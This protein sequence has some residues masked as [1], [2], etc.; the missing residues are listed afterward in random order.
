MILCIAILATI[1]LSLAK[2]VSF[3]K[4]KIQPKFNPQIRPQISPIIDLQ[5]INIIIPY[6]N[7]VLETYQPKQNHNQNFN[8]QSHNPE[9]VSTNNSLIF[10]ITGIPVVIFITFLMFFES[11]LGISEVLGFSNSFIFIELE[12]LPYYLANFVNPLI[13]YYQNKSLRKFVKELYCD[14]IF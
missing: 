7:Q 3:L 4:E 1:V 12:L 11:P 2:M 8:N 14:F 13:L 9:I 10:M 6:N 5:S